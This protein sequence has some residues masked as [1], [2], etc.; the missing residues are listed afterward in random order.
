MRC[1]GCGQVTLTLA[2]LDDGLGFLS[3]ELAPLRRGDLSLEAFPG[4]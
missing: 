4:P 3:D 1:L 2:L